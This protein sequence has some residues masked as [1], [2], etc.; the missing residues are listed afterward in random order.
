MQAKKHFSKPFDD[1]TKA[2]LEIFK[3]YLTEWLP[4]FISSKNNNYWENIIIYD[5]FAGEGKDVQ[6]NY[7]SPL[8][9][10]EILNKYND[11]VKSTGVKIKVI[12]NE[13]NYSSLIQLQNNINS[14]EYNREKIE[15]VLYNKP[16]NTLFNEIFPLMSKKPKIPRLMILDQ[17]GIK[18][19]TEEIF[20]K[21]IALERTDFVFFISS[22][23][24][25]RF[26]ELPEFSNY[27][28]I[29]KK[30]FD[31]SKPFHSHRVVFDYYKSLINND[32]RLAPFSIKKGINIY[33]LIFGSNHTYGLEKFLK[34][35]WNINP[36][37]GD[38]NYN[39]DGETIAE[40]IASLFE[41]YNTIKKIELLN[42]KLERNIFEKN[43]NSLYNLY[44]KT[45][46]FGCL[47]KHCNDYLRK[48]EKEKRIVIDGKLKSEKIHTLAKYS[49]VEIL[50]KK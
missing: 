2:K 13:A 40:G 8:L 31:E 29:K 49:D 10:L 36:H 37:T 12:L 32:Y 42:K 48:L 47:A 23:F 3:K 25:R 27:I 39:I 14:F 34:V 18:E 19:I 1:G 46:E 21:L 11:L 26:N 6:G 15:V 43:E 17:F 9:I 44:V 35:G 20:K 7:G 33:G 30:D 22:S 41:E 24:V 38:A 5:F 16:F 50:I 45:L 28:K 4:V